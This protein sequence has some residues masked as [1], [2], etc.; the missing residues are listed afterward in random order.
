[1][2][3]HDLGQES[4]NGTYSHSYRSLLSFTK[5]ASTK[6]SMSVGSSSLLRVYDQGRPCSVG[7]SSP[8]SRCF[9]YR[10][11]ATCSRGLESLALS[12]SKRGMGPR[13][14]VMRITTVLVLRCSGSVDLSKT[15]DSLPGEQSRRRAYHSAVASNRIVNGILT[16]GCRN[17]TY[18]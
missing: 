13:I 18:P 5:K 7:N 9:A 1:M 2:P 14:A 11:F 15:Q 8:T 16:Q 10:C 6:L 17:A 4:G 3:Q 12:L